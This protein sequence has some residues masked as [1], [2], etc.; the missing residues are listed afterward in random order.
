MNKMYL[1]CVMSIFSSAAFAMDVEMGQR[2]PAVDTPQCSI[3]LQPIDT[4]LSINSDDALVNGEVVFNCCVN[5]GV[6]HQYHAACLAEWVK[7]KI[8][9]KA[10]I[11]CPVCR[12]SL[13]ERLLA[14]V[15]KILG[16]VL[17]IQRFSLTEKCVVGL[18][19]LSSIGVF[20]YAVIRAYL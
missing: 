14:N 4:T 20:S 13:H 9:E 15:P 11:T 3:C 6:H 1:L 16:R 8:S 18:F 2:P 7:T 19:F 17:P 5:E 10:P 12:A